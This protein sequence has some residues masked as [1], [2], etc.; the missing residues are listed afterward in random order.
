M[1]NVSAAGSFTA[2]PNKNGQ[3]AQGGESTIEEIADTLTSSSSFNAIEAHVE[4]CQISSEVGGTQEAETS[5]CILAKE[6]LS[7]VVS[8]LSRGPMTVSELERRIIHAST[9]ALQV[10]EGSED[11]H[12]ERFARGDNEENAGNGEKLDG[13][14]NPAQIKCNSLPTIIDSPTARQQAEPTSKETR[15]QVQRRLRT[16]LFTLET[17]QLLLAN[18]KDDQL[19]FYLQGSV[20]G[21]PVIPCP[22]TPPPPEVPTTTSPKSTCLSTSVDL[23]GTIDAIQTSH[24]GASPL[25]SDSNRKSEE[26]SSKWRWWWDSLKKFAS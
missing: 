4:T 3:L 8:L 6:T 1:A 23:M 26:I 5:E 9:L 25:T 20:P 14:G 11:S 7:L 2:P 24:A 15:S 13:P 21:V 22:P 19:F 16:A 18:I 12:K 17:Q 10:P